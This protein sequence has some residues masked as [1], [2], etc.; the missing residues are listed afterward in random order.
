M[1]E[2]MSS[3][4]AAGRERE[5]SPGK[6]GRG[7]WALRGIGRDRGDDTADAPRYRCEAVAHVLH[8]GRFIC[9]DLGSATT[10]RLA[11]RWLRGRARDIADQLD[12]PAAR[13]VRYWLSDSTAHED[14][15]RALAGGESYLF[16]IRDEAVHYTLSVSPA[17]RTQ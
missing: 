9:L 4:L 1:H 2:Y 7:L 14:A 10:P 5:S 13:P 6:V 15:L 8:E 3:R 16:A 12:P 11:L 17:W